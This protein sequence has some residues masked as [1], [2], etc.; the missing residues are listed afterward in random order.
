MGLGKTIQII[1]LMAYLQEKKVKG[2]FIIAA[3][4][5]TLPNWIRE[6]KKWLPNV[7]IN[8]FHT[9]FS[10]FLFSHLAPSQSSS[11]I[12]HLVF[13][14]FAFLASAQM[15]TMLYHGSKA[16]RAD[17]RA[18]QF[19]LMPVNGAAYKMFPVWK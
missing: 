11:Y 15:P 9:C 6:F 7:S 1:A 10:S 14:C 17:L 4:L 19:K 2:P 3:P 8:T 5:A 16:E 18:Q 13:L 12:S